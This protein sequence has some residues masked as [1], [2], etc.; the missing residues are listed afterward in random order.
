MTIR[1]CT[2]IKEGD[3]GWYHIVTLHNINDIDAKEAERLL[4]TQDR[5]TLYDVRV[6]PTTGEVWIKKKDL[7]RINYVTKRSDAVDSGINN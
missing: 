2:N 1:E 7:N 6:H 5:S 4:T 3:R